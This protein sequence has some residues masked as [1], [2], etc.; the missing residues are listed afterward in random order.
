M[1]RHEYGLNLHEFEVG[2]YT[3]YSGG[4]MGVTDLV[5]FNFV[6]IRNLQ[7]HETETRGGSDHRPVTFETPDCIPLDKDFSRWNVRKL[8]DP[9]TRTQYTD[10]LEKKKL[11]VLQKVMMQLWLPKTKA[12]VLRMRFRQG[13]LQRLTEANRED[14]SLLL[15]R[16]SEMLST[17]SV[18]PPQK[19][20]L[21]PS[22]G[23]S[24]ASRVIAIDQTA[25]RI[26][27]L[28]THMLQHY[29]QT[30]GGDPAG[31]PTEFEGPKK[32]PANLTYHAPIYDAETILYQLKRLPHG[33]SAGT[34]EIMA[35]SLIHGD[36]TMADVLTPLFN[37]INCYATVPQEWHTALIVPIYKNKGSD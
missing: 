27:I 11:Y 5:I 36:K 10:A 6:D 28:S 33:K 21:A 31:D 7:V 25:S 16:Q 19:K 26:R 2:R 14:R 17:I 34:D 37:L 13:A 8:A 4:G 30:F 32:L 23:W 3:T 1:L 29:R 35:E 12:P 24:D 22:N 9:A 20:M 15:T 18:P